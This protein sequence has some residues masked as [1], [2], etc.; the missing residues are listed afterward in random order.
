MGGLRPVLIFAFSYLA[1]YLVIQGEI[2]Q[3]CH[4]DV[5][6]AFI[7]VSGYGIIIITSIA[8]I[9]HSF[10][11][12]NNGSTTNWIEKCK[13]LF[14]KKPSPPETPPTPPTNPI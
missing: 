5:I 13:E 4:E 14:L 3:A 7:Y 1:G 12:P 6:N 2:K 9:I 10:K 8:S 11:H